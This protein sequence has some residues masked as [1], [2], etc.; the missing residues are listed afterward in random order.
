LQIGSVGESWVNTRA[1]SSPPTTQ[2]ITPPT[3]SVPGTST[4]RP[5]ARS[6]SWCRRSSSPPRT[7]VATSWSCGKTVG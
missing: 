3:W 7:S 5:S 2:G 1:T 4:R 6:S